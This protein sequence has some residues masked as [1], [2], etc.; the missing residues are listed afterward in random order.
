MSAQMCYD[1]QTEILSCKKIVPFRQQ[2][3]LIEANASRLHT[4]SELKKGQIWDQTA[5]LQSHN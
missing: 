5:K 2:H 4:L 1:T 3:E